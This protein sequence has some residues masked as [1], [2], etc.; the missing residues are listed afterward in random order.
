MGVTF[1][2]IFVNRVFI[3][4]QLL[5]KRP[6]PNELKWGQFFRIFSNA[7]PQNVHKSVLM[8][9]TDLRALVNVG[10]RQRTWVLEG[11]SFGWNAE[12]NKGKT[13]WDIMVN[14]RGNWGNNK[15]T[16]G[17]S[18]TWGF[19]STEGARPFNQHETWVDPKHTIP[20]Q[21]YLGTDGHKDSDVPSDSHPSGRWWASL[22]LTFSSSWPS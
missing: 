8:E 6:I 15:G 22:L 4:N 18:I 2:L 12:F 14:Q 16:Y 21:V 20:P 10:L 11:G 7:I 1:L 17:L 13:L 19:W 5:Q 3:S 9:D